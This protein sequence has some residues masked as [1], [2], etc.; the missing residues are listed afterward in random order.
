MRR[1]VEVAFCLLLATSMAACSWVGAAE[2]PECGDDDVVE[3]VFTVVLRGVGI[4]AT[5][6]RITFDLG[7][8]MDVPT[9]DEIVTG[10]MDAFRQRRIDPE[11]KKRYCTAEVEIEFDQKKFMDLKVQET[12]GKMLAMIAMLRGEAW[13][14]RRS[15]NYSIQITDDG[16]AFVTVGE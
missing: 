2:V 8:A 16:S 1:F 13:L 9:F 5:D 12:E 15:V 10:G 6:D 11:I 7:G 3:Q 14:G 4:E